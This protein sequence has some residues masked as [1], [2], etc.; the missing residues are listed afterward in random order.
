MSGHE[1]MVRRWHECYVTGDRAAA[2]D[3][4]ADDAT[5]Q[6]SWWRD[7]LVGRDAI[8]VALERQFAGISDY[9]SEL[10]NL[11]SKDAVVFLEG[12]DNFTVDDNL[13]TLHWST[14]L[15]INAEGKIAQQRDYWD[16]RELEG[17][18]T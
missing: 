3:Y 18:P 11:V 16:T 14:V 6:V 12:I 8:E 4:Y 7:P 17:Q 15:E 2:I 13:L 5:W 1:D 10:V 9:R